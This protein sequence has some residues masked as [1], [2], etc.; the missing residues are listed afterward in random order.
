METDALWKSIKVASGNIFLMISTTLENADA[1]N[2]VSLF[3]VTTGQTVKFEQRDLGHKPK[4]RNVTY[5]ES[6]TLPTS[7]HIQFSYQTP[8]I[9]RTDAQNGVGCLRVASSLVD[10]SLDC[11]FPDL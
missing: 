6:R 11:R 8:Q 3:T 10:G 1:K 4:P 5:T 7:L 9:L 2:R